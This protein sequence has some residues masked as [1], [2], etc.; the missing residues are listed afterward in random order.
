M[1][2]VGGVQTSRANKKAG[3]CPLDTSCFLVSLA[4]GVGDEATAL[5]V[6]APTD[7]QLFNPGLLRPAISNLVLPGRRQ[8]RKPCASEQSWTIPVPAPFAMDNCHQVLS[9]G[10]DPSGRP[11]GG[12]GHS[13]SCMGRTPTYPFYRRSWFD[14]LT[15]NGLR[16]FSKR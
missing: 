9:I 14:R 8:A 16:L 5:R 4:A 15:T 12:L 2:G 11:Y 6:D 1:I 3:R 7:C 13:P 10:G